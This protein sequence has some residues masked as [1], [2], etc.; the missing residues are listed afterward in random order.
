[1][2]VQQGDLTMKG[3]AGLSRGS[4]ATEADATTL[5][6]EQ[7]GAVAYAAENG[8]ALSGLDDG[9]TALYYALS[10]QAARMS[11]FI[12]TSL[13]GAD[14]AVSA[15]GQYVLVDV[16]VSAGQSSATLLAQLQ[17]LGLKGGSAYAGVVSGELPVAALGGI[18]GLSA[19]GQA[20]ASLVQS[21]GV[22]AERVDLASSAHPS[23]DGT[24]VRLGIISDSFDKN[25]KASDHKVDNIASG[26]LPTDT[27][28]VLDYSGSGTDEGRAMAQLAHDAAPGAAIDFATGDNGQSGFANEIIALAQHGDK[29]IVDDLG[30]YGELMYQLGPIAQAIQTVTQAYGVTYLSAAGN[31]ANTGFEGAWKSG[32]TFTYNG[33]HYTSMNFGGTTSGAIAYTTGDYSDYG[34]ST[35]FALQ[36]DS[37]SA[38]AGN[39]S[40]GS[41][42]D[43]DLFFYSDAALTHLV[44]S[45]RS[46]NIGLDAKEL[47]QRGSLAE[48][49]TYYLQVGYNSDKGGPLPG[50]IRLI[51]ENDGLGGNFETLASNTNPGETYGHPTQGGSIAVGAAPYID[52]PAYT[53]SEP[54]GKIEYFSSVGTDTV[55]FA[56]NGTRLTTPVVGTVSIVGVDDVDTTFFGYDDDKNGFLNFSGTSAAAP[57]VAAVATRLIQANSA[58]TRDDILALIQDSA[59]DMDDPYTPGFDA[60]LDVASGAGLVQADLAVNFA[61]GGVISNAS[62]T[63]LYGTHLDD[64]IGGSSL[65]D[66]ISGGA[67]TN[68]I[69]GGDG[70]DTAIYSA[71]FSQYQVMTAADGSV[72]VAS[73]AGGSGAVNDT[74]TNVELLQFADR[75]VLL[76]TSL[77][78]TPGAPVQIISPQS[79]TGKTQI[80]GELNL[81]T[82]GTIAASS[83]VALK[84]PAAVFDTSGSG[85]GGTTVTIQ[86]L[87][88]VAGSAIR[89]G[90]GVL[91]LNETAA[92]T[93]AGAISDG[94]VAGGVGGGLVVNGSA[95]LTLT[96]ADTYTG[97]TQIYGQLDLAGSAVLNT[98][99]AVTLKSSSAVFDVSQATGKEAI[100]N[101]AGVAGS[102]IYLGASTLKINDSTPATFSGVISDGGVA[103]GVGGSLI[104]K[105]TASLN[106]TGNNTFTGGVQLQ[107]GVLELGSTTAAGAGGHALTFTGAATLQ[108]DAGALTAVSATKSTYGTAV[109]GFA[110]GD[111]IDLAALAYASGA[112]ATYT[113]T[114]L[115]VSSGGSVVTLSLTGLPTGQDFAAADDGHGHV[116]VGLVGG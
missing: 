34:Y 110:A 105:G 63:R 71:T 27:Q 8:G 62:Q 55:V 5:S 84:A 90:A 111:H 72:H 4:T 14:Q 10:P 102:H 15:D 113:G 52:T 91:S 87:S 39:G 114:T 79:Y 70:S 67:G 109:A 25:T 23:I 88:G 75:T 116:L 16:S 89:L 45:A 50:E 17:G 36:W 115:K 103:G 73:T 54:N 106:L 18:S 78:V 12:S 100:L 93:Y 19:L 38:S 97:K 2:H 58:L 80:S 86:E 108:L 30:Y 42:N 32:T 53:P 66:V 59:L 96:G 3:A 28:V 40:P 33:V 6:I 74:L 104:V 81:V 77:T 82:G 44:A 92:A 47:I 95:P 37:T 22:H 26:D 64:T 94:G 49:T 60:G 76:G 1:M 51:A 29:V 46:N 24:G 85:A 112:T 107:T 9:L 20:H 43:L 21:Q 61:L 35:S 57:D 83:Q 31:D 56:N 11:A 99:K 101:L 69:N 68:T 7:A 41:S 13:N 48:D 98:S 65:S